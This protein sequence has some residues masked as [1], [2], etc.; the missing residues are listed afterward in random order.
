MVAS[1]FSEIYGI[2]PWFTNLRTLV[3]PWW[4][5]VASD[6]DDFN[7]SNGSAVMNKQKRTDS[8]TMF[9]AWSFQVTVEANLSHD[10]STQ[11]AARLLSEHPSNCTAHEIRAIGT[12]A[13]E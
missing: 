3:P 2:K 7:G 8:G 11:A 5:F 1:H 12:A 6:C 4:V 10:T 9:W 13:M